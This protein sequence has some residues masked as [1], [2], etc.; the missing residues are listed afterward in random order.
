[1][2]RDGHEPTREPGPTTLFP[3]WSVTRA[4]PV[5]ALGTTAATSP[6][7]LPGAQT[8]GSKQTGH[9]GVN[10]DQR[11]AVQVPCGKI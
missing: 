5:S 6:R 4:R 1:M 9:S 2:P 3:F 7:H 11:H 8:Q 10:S